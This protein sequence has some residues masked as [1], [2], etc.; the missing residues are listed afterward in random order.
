[1]SNARVLRR[2]MK[3]SENR[4]KRKLSNMD[5]PGE[6]IDRPGENM[7]PPGETMARPGEKDAVSTGPQPGVFYFYVI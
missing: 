3:Q 7:D 4:N 5:P 1:M 6:N 2:E